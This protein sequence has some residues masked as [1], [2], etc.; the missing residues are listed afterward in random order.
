VVFETTLQFAYLAG[1][2]VSALLTG[3]LCYWVVVRTAMPG[4][5][6][7]GLFA[8]AGTLWAAVTAFGVIFD[9]RA[10]LRWLELLH[11]A[12]ALVSAGF[13]LSFA[14][15]YSGRSV[16]DSRGIQAFTVVGFL[17]LIAIF[18]EPLHGAYWADTTLH[19]TPFSHLQT[20]FGLLNALVVF[21]ILAAALVTFY[22]FLEL[23]LNSQRRPGSALLSLLGGLLIAL[24]PFALFHLGLTPIATYDPTALGIGGFAIAFAFA[25]FRLG[26]LDIAP[27]ARDKTVQ[28]L[29]DPYLAINDKGQLVDY[30]TA[31]GRVFGISDGELGTPLGDISQTLHSAMETVSDE[32]QRLPTEPGAPDP[33][34]P[35]HE[36]TLE[37][38]GETYEYDLNVSPIRGPRET[39]QGSQI[40]LR[41]I[42][43]LKKR[44]RTLRAFQHRTEAILEESDRQGVCAA[45]VRAIEEVL[46][47]PEVSA[48]LYDRRADALRQAT[49]TTAF[50][51]TYPMLD[52]V[53]R[54]SDSPLWQAYLDDEVM[55]LTSRA[56]L[57]DLLLM[58][59]PPARTAVLFPLGSHGVILL[60]PANAASFD[61]AALNYCQLLSTTVGAAL[62]RV[63]REQGLSTVQ[64]IARDALSA[65]T[66]S[67]M[68]DT[69]LNQLPD[70]LN[71]PLC[72]IW[73][74]NPQREQLE[75]L[76]VTGPA[77]AMYDD[78]PT[79]QP[80]NSISWRVF[81]AGET[82]LITRT[83]DH[84]EVYDPDGLIQS[85]IV[86]PIGEF[87]VLMAASEHEESFSENERQILATLA[88]NLQ[89][90]SRLINR[91][92]DMRLLDQVLGRVLRHNLRNKLMVIQGN[93]EK[94]LDAESPDLTAPAETI[95][96]ACRSLEQVAE[97]AQAMREIIQNREETTPMSLT[98]VTERAVG[99]VQ[100]DFPDAGIETTFEVDP[101]VIAH[102]NLRLCIDQIVRNAIE[103]G[104]AGAMSTVTVQVLEGET[105]PVVEVADDG[106]GIPNHELHVID[107]HGESAL[108]HGS[109][110]GLWI[111]D[112]VVEYSNATVSFSYD[113]GA[114]VRITF[115]N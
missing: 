98:E 114:V 103:H 84:P 39:R 109:G 94:L 18:T 42:T 54:A 47:V 5:L 49:A 30:N 91:R 17:L 40:V 26:L 50:T 108:E 55:E 71:F 43:Q 92:R 45:T 52:V 58:E 24:T 60:T 8:L 53:Q 65:D 105:G 56:A 15:A 90:A 79:F 99:V 23:Y 20:A 111:V 4:R 3:G 38:D 59:Q 1:Y 102:P 64:S 70:E 78:L 25:G 100:N 57:S 21:V 86:S 82:R 76:G 10:L 16:R 72:G 44:E 87:G 96:G 61:D 34:N 9:G 11:D 68:A 35:V 93:A 80:G 112:R 41:D 88:T 77:E 66:Q 101:Q 62:D 28:Q 12:S 97:N 48:Y 37:I 6:Y 81:E 46:D 51:D 32:G 107:Q 83:S 31:A 75:P 73:E 63:Q 85:E 36:I 2:F 29:S 89:T 33:E 95:L 115:P 104:S 27:V 110:V 13:L 106:P 22:Y 113:D 67:E 69:V 74:H 19:A 14:T 7:F